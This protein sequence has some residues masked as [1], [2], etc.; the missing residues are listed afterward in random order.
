MLARMWGKRNPLT[1]LVGLSIT[2]TTMEKL[3]RELP[4]DPAI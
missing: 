2:T 4:Y 3:K 1:L